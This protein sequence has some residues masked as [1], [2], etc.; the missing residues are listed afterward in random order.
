MVFALSPIRLRCKESVRIQ[1]REVVL[2]VSSEG[3]P[4]MNF[5]PAAAASPFGRYS[6]YRR[7]YVVWARPWGK[8]VVA[9]QLIS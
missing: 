5:V 3:V 6:E 8:F 9:P 2:A 4:Q 1:P 7:V